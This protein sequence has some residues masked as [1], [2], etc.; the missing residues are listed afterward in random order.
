MW[1]A[2]PSLRG[3]Q[4]LGRPGKGGLAQR[5]M[6]DWVPSMRFVVL[7]IAAAAIGCGL[8]C[9]GFGFSAPLLSLDTGATCCAP[10]TTGGCW[11][12]INYSG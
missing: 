12:A 1:G 7:F 9:I 6:Q 4:L 3:H 8:V 11:Q 10:V 2:A 5:I